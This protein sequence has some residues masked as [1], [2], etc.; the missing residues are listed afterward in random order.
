[1]SYKKNDKTSQSFHYLIV[2]ETE[3]EQ[4]LVFGINVE[5]H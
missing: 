1:M 4:I 2:M 5:F 3:Y